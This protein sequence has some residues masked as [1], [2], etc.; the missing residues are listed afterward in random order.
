MCEAVVH[1]NT[2]R[3]WKHLC[4]VLQAAERRGKHKPVEVALKIAPHARMGV[5]VVLES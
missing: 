4:F 1:K 2:A 3:Q 5:V